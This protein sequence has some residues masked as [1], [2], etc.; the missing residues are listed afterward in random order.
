MNY[1]LTR[2]LP[3]VYLTNLG[4]VYPDRNGRFKFSNRLVIVKRILLGTSYED[5]VMKRMLGSWI[6]VLGAMCVSVAVFAVDAPFSTGAPPTQVY[7][8]VGGDS[9]SASLQ[10]SPV[11]QVTPATSTPISSSTSAAPDMTNG[12]AVINSAGV[13]MSLQGQVT[14]LNQ[15]S[16]AFEQHADLSIQNLNDSNRAMAIAIQ[17]I[18]Q[19]IAVLQQQVVA[20]Q[21]DP[22]ATVASNDVSHTLNHK[23]YGEYLDFGGAAVFMLGFGVVLGRFVRRRSKV[24]VVNSMQQKKINPSVILEEDTKNEYDFMGTA[25]AI[26]AKLDLARSYVAMNDYEQAYVVLKTVMEKGTEEQRIEA[27]LLVNKMNSRRNDK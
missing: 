13:D 22:H 15:A 16:A 20:L 14:Q 19:N 23:K 21:A 25:E 3:L 18:N 27:Q 1:F 5:C 26:P 12:A 17:S 7:H 24:T 2:Y 8:A 10:S 6:V 9:S 4:E 11:V